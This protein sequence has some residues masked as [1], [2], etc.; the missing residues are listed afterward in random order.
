M[1]YFLE[2]FYFY[3]IDKINGSCIRCQKSDISDLKQI[4]FY[5]KH[6]VK[7]DDTDIK[8]FKEFLWLSAP[9]HKFF[10]G[11]IVGIIKNP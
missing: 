11:D 4:Y 7:R 8:N 3:I 10:K 6:K 2:E 9:P 1:R 5:L